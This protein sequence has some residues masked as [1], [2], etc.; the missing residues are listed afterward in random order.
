MSESINQPYVVFQSGGNAIANAPSYTGSGSDWTVTYTVSG[1][2][3]DGS[4][5]FTIDASDNAGNVK[6]RTTTTNSSA[7]T[8]DTTAPTISSTTLSSNNTNLNLTFSENVYNTSTGS[9]D[10]ETSDFTVAIANGSA[11]SPTLTAISKVSQNVYDISLS[12]SGTANGAETITINPASSAVFDQAGNAA[13]TSQ[14]N[15]TA[16]MNDLAGPTFSSVDLS[17][18]NAVST[19]AKL[20]DTISINITTSESINQPYVV[21]QSGGAAITNSPSYT[22]SGSEWT[23][24]YT[25]NSSDTDGSVTFTIDASDNAGNS[26]TQQTATTNSSSV[27]VDKTVPTFSSTAL[28]SDNTNITITFSENVY[29]TATGSGDL[30]ISDF[31]ASVSGGTATSPVLTAITKTSQSVYDLSLSFT[32]TADGSETITINPVSSGI[33]DQAGNEASTTQSNNTVTLNDQTTPTLT[34]VDLS[35]NNSIK[36]KYAGANDVVTLNITASESINQPYVVFQSGGAAITNS[37]SYSGSGTQWSV[38][39]TVSSSD[40]NGAVSFTIDA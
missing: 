31:S 9:G 33:F 11:T 22:G 3:T 14:S 12:F 37:P 32:N 39:Y 30:E 13:T 16:S 6:Q 17:S 24:T 1:S 18:N 28:S 21:F 8:T 38:F 15:N 40:T 29:N 25:V 23:V 35:S 27:N 36:T 7:V 19:L 5:S 10:L 20:A 4:I 26:A 34:T 2:D